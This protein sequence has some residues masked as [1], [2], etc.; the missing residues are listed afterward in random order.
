[1][2]KSIFVLLLALYGLSIKAQQVLNP[3]LRI[4]RSSFAIIVD[5]QS[6]DMCRKQ[7][8]DYQQALEDE[9]LPTFIIADQWKSPESVKEQIIRL[10][11]KDKLEGVALVG[12][13]PI[14]LIRKAQ[15]LTS[16]FKMDEKAPMIE[17]SVPSDRFYDDF[18]LKF[19][20]I[21]QDSTHND[22]FYYNLSATSIQYIDCN[23]YSGRIKPVKNGENPYV[24]LG[25]YLEKIVRLHKQQNKLNQFVSYTGEGS[26]SNSLTA[27]TPEAF[28]L[29]E[30]LPQVF[31]ADGRAAFYRYDMWSYPKSEI[32]SQLK[33]NDLDLIIFHSHGM[34]YRQYLSAIPE[35]NSFE[36]HI[37]YMKESLRELARRYS[38]R[39]EEL[40][41]YYKLYAEKY[42][43]DSTWFAGYDNKRI[44][45]KDSV[46]DIKRGIVLEDI[47]SIRPNVRFAIF[48]ACYNGDFREENSIAGSYVFS[49]GDCAAAYANSV[50]VLQDKQ[51]EEL[52]GMLGSG[53]RIG[54]WAQEINI[55]ESHIIGDPTFRFTSSDKAL[56][57][58]DMRIGDLSTGKLLRWT[59]KDRPCALQSLALHELYR[60]G[61]KHISDLLLKKYRTTSYAMVRY[62]CFNL[63]E[64]K[65]DANFQTILKP[66]VKD[67]YEFIRRIAI[68]RMG[69][70]GLSEYLPYLINAY[71]DEPLSARI[72]FNVQSAAKL[73]PKEEV[74][75]VADSCFAHSYFRN[76]K[77]E[78]NKFMEKTSFDMLQEM[79]S[80]L[81]SKT[82]SMNKKNFYA[83]V[84]KNMTYHPA[85]AGC[86]RLIMDDGQPLNL[87]I[88][89]L[90]SLAW[91]R[92]SYK[93][94]LITKACLS[95]MHNKS[96][97][98]LLR[99]EA[100]RTYNRLID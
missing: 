49:K 13:I 30:Q 68:D 59:Q 93:K 62:T 17:S 29:R 45:Q 54:Q 48:D 26:F 65:N 89:V 37:F 46:N 50:N 61:Y 20:F 28:N 25:D 4:R 82:A 80:V 67:P 19:D 77:T 95:I 73:Y 70:T 18:G 44:T 16:A 56:D 14:A 94:E 58:L 7:L 27:W 64:K 55:L 40:R 23:I 84:L 97:D 12:D 52:L 39:P 76:K 33:R 21:K 47:P 66:A 78:E 53:A 72:V 100:T 10:Y 92:L 35:T 75:A 69:K 43:I 1:M 98:S 90:Q 86:I 15:H 83:G 60:R 8:L 38:K 87:R 36:N 31:D 22:F 6:F 3:H 63:L 34:P 24:Q 32:I 99:E 57:L 41:N 85:V 5:K 79:D 42:G 9:G 81:T 74:K 51:S 71:I 2:R 11:K 88:N 96:N 91:F